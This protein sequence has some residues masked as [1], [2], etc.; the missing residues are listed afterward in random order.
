LDR[1]AIIVIIAGAMWTLWSLLAAIIAVAVRL[2]L[3][4][5]RSLLFLALA[6]AAFALLA[7]LFAAAFA[8]GSLAVALLR[9]ALLEIPLRVFLRRAILAFGFAWWTGWRR[10]FAIRRRSDRLRIG[11]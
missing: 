6:V 11:N 2:V 9:I 4:A 5:A 10:G 7:A 1:T 3:L 8:R